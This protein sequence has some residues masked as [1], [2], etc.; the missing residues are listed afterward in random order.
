[1][2]L[3]SLT[4]ETG[5]K[6]QVPSGRHDDGNAQRRFV[7]D[8]YLDPDHSLTLNVVFGTVKHDVHRKRRAAINNFFS[9]KA[10]TNVEPM[11]QNMTNRL[12][13]NLARAAALD[14][15]LEMRSQF[16]A[17]TTDVVCQHTF[18]K[19]LGLLHSTKRAHDWKAT[20]G[21]I[22]ILTPLAKQFTWII[23]M[24]L[25]VPV[26]LLNAVVPSLGRIVKL[27]RVSYQDQAHLTVSSAIQITKLT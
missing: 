11:I 5:R 6:R 3:V 24:A 10:I 20:I 22:A 12:C 7:H 27:H 23:P 17:V 26:G 25:K 8:P 19:N 2:A 15:E 18:Q 21:A 4:W 1:M 16:L 13:E 9:K 14:T